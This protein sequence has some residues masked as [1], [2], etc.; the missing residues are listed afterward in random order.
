MV[1]NWTLFFAAIPLTS[2]GVATIVFHIQPVW[3]ILYSAVVLREAVPRRQQVATVVALGGLALTTGLFGSGTTAGFSSHDYVLGLL[4]CLGGSLSYAAVTILAK[5]ETVVSSFAIAWWQCA[6]GVLAVAWAPL[7][8]GWPQQAS[9]WAW[10]AGLGV[11]HTGLAYAILF[12]GM[13]RLSLGRVAV[14]QYVYPF[15]A[16]LLD[17][18]VYDKTLN[19]VQLAGI[20]VM[21]GALVTMR[22]R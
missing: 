5:Q 10:L 17:W 21:G 12:A 18:L 9:V 14:L 19:F 7:V 20:A 16:V 22:S 11:L 6:I 1:L 15:T 3:L 8:H 2:I 13:A 4:L